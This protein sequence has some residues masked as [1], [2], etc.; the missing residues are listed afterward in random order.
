MAISLLVQEHVKEKAHGQHVDH[1]L[2]VYISLEFT[3]IRE[4]R[5][6]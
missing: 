5:A 4:L 3:E 2:R 6:T 1:E